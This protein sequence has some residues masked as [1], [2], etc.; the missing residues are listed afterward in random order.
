MKIR[1]SIQSNPEGSIYPVALFPIVK[2]THR[3]VLESA[4]FSC[5]NVCC[6]FHMFKC[7]CGKS[8]VHP[9]LQSFLTF[10][11]SSPFRLLQHFNI[12]VSGLIQY[13]FH[14]PFHTLSGWDVYCAHKY[15]QDSW[16]KSWLFTLNKNINATCKVLVP[17]SMSWNKISQKCSVHTKSLFLTNVVHKFPYIPV[18]VHFSINKVIH[19]PDRC[20]ISR[21]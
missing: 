5:W 11:H 15:S 14:L 12:S 9:I 2:L 19:P 7:I 3:L 21:S 18:S 13:I 17:C 16:G 6:C 4:F 20:G 10:H 8:L 1:G